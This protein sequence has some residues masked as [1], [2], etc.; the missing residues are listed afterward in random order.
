MTTMKIFNS[1][2]FEGH[3]AHKRRRPKAH[4]L[5]YRVFCLSL[6]IDELDTLHRRLKWFSVNSFNVMSFY[7]RDHGPGT[8]ESLRPWVERHLQQA[9]VDLEGGS[10]KVVC[11]PRILGYAFNPLTTYFCYHQDGTLRAMLYEVSNTFGQRHSYLFPIKKKARRMFRHS[12]DKRFYV[13]PF[14]EV[15]GQYE[16]SVRPLTDRLFLHIRQSDADGPVLDA[17]TTGHKKHLTDRAIISSLLRYPLLTLKIIAGI[18]WEALR[19]WSK[20]IATTERPKPPGLPVT[21]VNDQSI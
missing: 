20:G 15:A 10:I 21:I 7:D 14:L 3:V 16:F 1:C 18:H 6:D 4:E 13:S 2:I 11:Y 5:R 12:C 17:W 9:D 19:L 8:N